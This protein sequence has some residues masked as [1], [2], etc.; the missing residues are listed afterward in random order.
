MVRSRDVPIYATRLVDSGWEICAPDD[1]PRQP[2]FT[3][4]AVIPDPDRPG[5]Q[6]DVAE[7]LAE[8]ARAAGVA[9]RLRR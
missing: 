7:R 8:I 9:V 3:V 5:P 6:L 1:D 4:I 2:A